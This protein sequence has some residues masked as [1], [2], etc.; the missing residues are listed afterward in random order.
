MRDAHF[1][2]GVIL[3]VMD[4]SWLTSRRTPGVGTAVA[5]DLAFRH[6]TL[7][8]LALSGEV[9]A[10]ATAPLNKEALHLG[11]HNYPGGIRNCWPILRQQRVRD[12]ALYDKLK[13]IHIST[14]ISLRKFLDTLNGR[15]G[16]NG[17]SC[18]ETT[19]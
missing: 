8:T 11:G 12:G 16:Q 5:G 9:K 15:K 2:P 7:T 1:A 4:D 18:C 17:Y 10:I 14:H 13:V 6:Q 19:S 3:N